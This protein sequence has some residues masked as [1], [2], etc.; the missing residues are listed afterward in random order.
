VRVR[1]QRHRF[2][3]ALVV[4]LV[5]VLLLYVAT[6]TGWA[7]LQDTRSVTSSGVGTL[8]D[9]VERAPA[10]VATTEEYGP[11]GPVS[12]VYAG[13][14][15]ASGLFGELDP[16]WLAVSSQSGDTRALSAPGL[17]APD[18]G[19]ISV[20]PA[21]DLL[22]WVT[23]GSVR[24]YGTASGEVRDLAESDATRVGAFSPDGSRLLV[25][26]DG[27]VVLDVGSGEAVARFP[28]SPGT[29]R[30]AA[31][32]P[33]NQRV[34]FVAGR[35]LVTA[36]ASD[37][38][39][40]RTP[41]DIPASAGLAWS[42][43]GERLASLQR[44]GGSQRLFVSSLSDDGQVGAAEH[45]EVPGVSLQRLLG[46]S[47]A[48]TVAV[49]AYALETGA[50]ERV[51]DIPLDGAG[52]TDLTILPGPG[53]NWAGTGTMAVAGSTLAYGSADF[54]ERIWPWSHLARLVACLVL[55][56]FLFGLYVTRRPR[57]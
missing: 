51:L 21:G 31:W 19:A 26:G 27:L 39:L 10:S 55:G 37:G 20:S 43:S 22:A 49:V 44:A 40:T 11:L 30:R 36:D 34:D 7:A 54:P 50:Q 33:D 56:L 2:V 52:P 57:H 16:A 12:L 35:V 14:H 29:A 28:A 48:G 47:G 15:V 41:S 18:P 9:A 6:T 38:T 4:T 17:P 32:R 13:T 23:G 1:V 45:V 25:E 5:G 24:V 53:E 46:W 42:P 8:P 3:T